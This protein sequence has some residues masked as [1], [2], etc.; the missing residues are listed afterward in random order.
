M[1]GLSKRAIRTDFSEIVT[2]SPDT[3]AIMPAIIPIPTNRNTMMATKVP[4]KLAR[5]VLRKFIE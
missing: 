4:S 5:N 2:S 1:I 3:A